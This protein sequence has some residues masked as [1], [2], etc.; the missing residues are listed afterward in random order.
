M[1]LVHPTKGAESI[2]LTDLGIAMVL[3]EVQKPNASLPMDSTELPIVTVSRFRHLLN[4]EALITFTESEIV[5]LV[6]PLHP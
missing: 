4:A 5:M 6:T 3:N 1:R 2:F